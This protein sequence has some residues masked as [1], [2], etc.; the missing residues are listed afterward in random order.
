MTTAIALRRGGDAWRGGI[1]AGESIQI[2]VTRFFRS[3][4]G[5]SRAQNPLATPEGQPGLVMRWIDVKGPLAPQWP[6]APYAVLFDD[7]P[8]KATPKGAA[9][10][11]A[12]TPRDV[13]AALAQRGLPQ[14]RV[15]LMRH[16]ETRAV[17]M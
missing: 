12:V 4:P 8:V 3:R 15:W 11:Y 2:D 9:L 7:L 10:P 17:P 6:S 14:D 1:A 5:A 13:A 16:G